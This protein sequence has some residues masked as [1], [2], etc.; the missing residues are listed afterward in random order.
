MKISDLK[1]GSIV[2]FVGCRECTG[3]LVCFFC[4]KGVKTEGKVVALYKDY[5][6]PTA[7][8]KVKGSDAMLELTEEDLN[9]PQLVKNVSLIGS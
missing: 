3:K 5:R 9:D 6:I 4:K 2:N 7:E 8:V 1:I